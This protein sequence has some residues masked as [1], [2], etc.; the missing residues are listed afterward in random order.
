VINTVLYV[1]IL[2]IKQN[3]VFFYNLLV[4]ERFRVGEYIGSKNIDD[5]WILY[6]FSL[7]EPSFPGQSKTVTVEQRE[8]AIVQVLE[9]KKI[10]AYVR[11]K[12]SKPGPKPAKKKA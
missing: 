6:D 12:G 8:N 7:P 5:N 1:N 2:D 11:P 4:P 10:R 3:D 9:K